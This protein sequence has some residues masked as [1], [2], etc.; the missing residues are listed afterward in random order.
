[1][2]SRVPVETSREEGVAFFAEFYGGEEKIPLAHARGVR[3][4]I[5]ASARAGH[6]TIK[7]NKRHR[8]GP[9]R[10]RHPT[11]GDALRILEIP[12]TE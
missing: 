9:V 10:E 3:V 6:Y 7:V 4:A 1:V 12:E 11:L 8:S 5:L 2:T